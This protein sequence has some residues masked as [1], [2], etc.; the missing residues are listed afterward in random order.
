[1]ISMERKP[2]RPNM[3]LALIGFL[4][5][6][7]IMLAFV[8]SVQTADKSSYWSVS[9]KETQAVAQAAS[10]ARKK[11]PYVPT[12]APG[13]PVLTP[14]PDAVH[15]QPA[16]RTQAEQYVIQAGDTL[17]I[18]AKRYGVSIQ[19]LVEANNLPNPDVV[20]VGQLLE[21]LPRNPQDSASD[22]KIIPDS[23]LVYG[24]HSVDFDIDAFAREKNGQLA[25]Y[26]EMVSGVMLSGAQ[27]IQQVAEDFSVNPRLL[28]A[29]LE[30]Q[31]GWVTR[32]V[33]PTLT[34]PSP[35]TPNPGMLDFPLM[36]DPLRVG[37]YS[38]L[39]FAANELNRGFYLWRA[40]GAATWLLADGK[41]VPVSPAINAG[42]AGVQQLMATI[43]DYSRW[44]QAVSKDGVFA[45][46]N[47][48]FGYPFDFAVE[49][50]VAD[51]LK[52]PA[53]QL[54]FEAGKGWIFTGGPHGGWETVLPG[55]R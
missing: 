45:A 27:I 29:V 4:A 23:E 14:T 43:S 11:I 38:Q 37:L 31:S 17:G 47:S 13:D 30:Y 10:S 15:A 19:Q 28:L 22:F 33:E 5:I 55:R 8:R 48:L 24:P 26:Q 42:T 9:G 25:D 39:S 2:L 36:Q 12:R 7:G 54:P 51:D 53:M 32:R 52:Q 41:V 44:Q 6:F 35:G 18:V 50:L 3:A 21:I 20:S 40:K 16:A 46:Y 49:P 34:A 1:M